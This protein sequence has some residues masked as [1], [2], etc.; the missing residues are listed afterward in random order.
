MGFVGCTSP[1]CQGRSLDRGRCRTHSSVHAR[2]FL[3]SSISQGCAQSLG[4][5]Q[6]VCNTA[7][8]CFHKGLFSNTEVPALYL[9]RRRWRRTAKQHSSLTIICV[10][11]LSFATMFVFPWA[12][13]G[14]QLWAL[15]VPPW[16]A[17]EHR[18]LPTERLVRTTTRVSLCFCCGAFPQ[19]I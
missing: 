4:P 9:G 11:V 15:L 3:T 19:T 10:C 12:P 13:L 8:S 17:H 2:S 7:L 5:V 14:G 18:G 6:G 1:H 16:H